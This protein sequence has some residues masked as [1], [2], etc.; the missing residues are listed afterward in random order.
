MRSSPD[1]RVYRGVLLGLGGI[2]RNG[3]LP[4]F[5]SES[6][7]KIVGI[8]DDAVTTPI[9]GLPLLSGPEQI[10]ELGPIDFVDVCTPTS[11]HVALSLWALSQGY[12]VLCEK[13]VAVTRAEAAAL[14]AAA[15]GAG[16]IVMPCHQYRFNPVWRR[17]KGWLDEE[18]IGRWYLAE[19]RVYRLAADRGTDTSV[20]PW[21]GRRAA[22][23]GGVP[24]GHRTPLLDPLLDPGGAPAT[25]RISRRLRRSWKT[26]TRERRLQSYSSHEPGVA[27][28]AVRP[29]REC[30]RLS[31]CTNRHNGADGRRGAHRL[32]VRADRRAL[33]AGVRLQRARLAAHDGRRSAAAVLLAY[34]CRTDLLGRVELP[35]AAHQRRRRALSCGGDGALARQ[36]ARCRLGDPASHAAFLHLRA[37]LAHRGAAGI[38]ALAEG[39]ASDCVDSAGRCSRADSRH[40]CAVLV[41]APPWRSG[42]DPEWDA[43]RA[44]HQ[45]AGREAR[46]APRSLRRA[47]SADH[48]FLSS[49][50]PAF[51]AGDCA[52]VPE[53]VPLHG[54]AGADRGEPRIRHRLSAR[55]FD[56]RARGDRQQRALLRS[57][58][59]GRSRGGVLSAV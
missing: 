49:E 57:V 47:R 19:F 14:A 41:R 45:S 29:R 26:R 58:R 50:S 36:T 3:H 51:R 35:D 46:A 8:V 21:R 11:S 54:R 32:D 9:D 52:R 6:R 5:Q 4:A 7:L 23:P 27:T 48:R 18:V 2:A 33:R 12:H 30:L 17:V 40:P 42:A 43:A 53:S 25:S 1:Q 22:G 37:R 24:P 20:V 10:A 59:S 56:R 34:V 31:R 16:R 13:P 15:Q 55:V 28:G 44:A 38:C 39:H